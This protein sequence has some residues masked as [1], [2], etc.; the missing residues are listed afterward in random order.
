MKGLPGY[1]RKF[2]VYISSENES[3]R[4]NGRVLGS[5]MNFTALIWKAQWRILENRDRE[6]K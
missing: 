6:T 3:L 5:D 1:T 2:G 4:L